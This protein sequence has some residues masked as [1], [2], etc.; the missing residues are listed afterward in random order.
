[1]GNNFKGKFSMIFPHMLL[2]IY[3]SYFNKYVILQ[4][5]V[6]DKVIE[7]KFYLNFEGPKNGKYS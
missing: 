6:L 3:L 5:K 2:C 4:G 7:N 1:M